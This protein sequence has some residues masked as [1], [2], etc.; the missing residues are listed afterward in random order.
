[1]SDK[2]R[3]T[4]SRFCAS[5]FYGD[6]CKCVKCCEQHGRVYDEIEEHKNWVYA[7]VMR[8]ESFIVENAKPTSYR[9]SK[10]NLR[11]GMKFNYFFK[12]SISSDKGQCKDC[13][14]FDKN[15]FC[16]HSN[17]KDYC[18]DRDTSDWCDIDSFEKKK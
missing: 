13:I 15:G 18:A 6:E 2:I 17:S 1:M 8:G 14:Y 4:F 9:D 12:A 5:G 3:I 7:Q 10:N 16:E 11:F